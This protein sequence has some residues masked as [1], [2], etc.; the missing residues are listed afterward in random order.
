MRIRKISTLKCVEDQIPVSETWKVES[1]S[2]CTDNRK[3]LFIPI[4]LPG[5][6]KVATRHKNR[7]IWDAWRKTRWSKNMHLKNVDVSTGSG[8]S[9]D[10][11]NVHESFFSFL[12]DQSLVGSMVSPLFTSFLPVKWFKA[13]QLAA[14]TW[15]HHVF[16]W[17]R[18]K[19]LLLKRGENSS[20]SPCA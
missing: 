1:N 13:K 6:V 2:V 20:P 3:S 11:C 5:V 9:I 8:F 15:R 17:D 19:V 16:H 10:T 14:S 18:I 12:L 4:I 7:G